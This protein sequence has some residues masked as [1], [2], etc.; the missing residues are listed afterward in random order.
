MNSNLELWHKFVETKDASILDELLAENVQFHS[1]FVWKPKDGKAITSVILQTAASVFEDFR[2]VRQ[3]LD[4]NNWCLEFEAKIGE[5]TLRG[6]DIIKF[7]NNKIVDF[8]VMIR[9]ANALQ[10]LGLEMGKRLG[11]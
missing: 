5:L 3:I 1:P 7:E 4:E 10:A 6:V 2:Y 9:P 8:E 11:L